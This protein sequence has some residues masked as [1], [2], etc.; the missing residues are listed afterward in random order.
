MA[1][2][3]HYLS[4]QILDTYLEITAAGRAFLNEIGGPKH[5][6]RYLHYR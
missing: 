5:V 3:T 1:M 4:P 6:R 2:L